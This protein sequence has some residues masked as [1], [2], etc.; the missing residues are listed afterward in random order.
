VPDQQLDLFSGA[1][2]GVQWRSPPAVEHPLA[3]EQMDDEALIAAIGGSSFDHS[4]ALAA[5]AGR[6]QLAAAVPALAALCRRFAGFG[7]HRLVPEQAAALHGLAMIGGREAARAVASM[8]ER[9]V[10]QGPTLSVAVGA[11]ARLRS[12]LGL[13]ILRALLRHPDPSVRA[14]ACRCARALPEIVPL[15]TDLL[16]DLDRTVTISA[17]CALGHLGRIEAR[18]ALKRMLREEPSEEAIDAISTIADEECMVLLGR[19]AR[20]MPAL[21]DAALDALDSIDH[22]R[23]AAIAAA[24]RVQLQ[25]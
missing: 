16:D 12:I 22:A 8:L 25:P 21:A 11:A 17:A 24:A 14:D 9:A 4:M 19:L 18:P 15:L 6:R 10:V 3:P 23:A 20:S 5:E 1:P 7:I 13:E 2:V